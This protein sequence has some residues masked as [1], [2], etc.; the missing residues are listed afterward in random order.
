MIAQNRFFLLEICT[1][2]HPLGSRH[3]DAVRDSSSPRLWRPPLITASDSA[4]L[5]GEKHRAKAQIQRI[6]HL[7]ALADD[8]FR[9]QYLLVR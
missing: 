1:Q 6:L 5:N 9:A 4:I 2:A 7:P 3:G 8:Q